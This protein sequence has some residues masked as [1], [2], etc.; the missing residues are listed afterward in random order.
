MPTDVDVT[1]WNPDG[2]SVAG[3]NAMTWLTTMAAAVQAELEAEV[4]EAP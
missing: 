3:F 2:S 1:A 4:P